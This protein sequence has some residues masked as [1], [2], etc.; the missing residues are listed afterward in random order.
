[1][2]RT[3]TFILAPLLLVTVSLLSGQT[4]PAQNAEFQ[5]LQAHFDRVVNARH[6]NLFRG[7]T[8]V[9]QWEERRRR[10][11]IELSRSLWHDYAWP[12]TPPPARI[13]NVTEHPAYTI[14]NVV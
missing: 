3:P 4:R 8:T 12:S 13:T 5:A 6:E 7:L 11:R 10:V 1:M 14:E 9:P 2:P